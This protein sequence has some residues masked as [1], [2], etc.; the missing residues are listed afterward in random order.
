MDVNWQDDR[1][2]TAL[3]IAASKGHLQIVQILM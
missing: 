1:G 2:W 3:M